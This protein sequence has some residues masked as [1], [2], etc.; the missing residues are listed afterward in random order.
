MSD[1]PFDESNPYRPPSA[2]LTDPPEESVAALFFATSQAKLAIMSIATLGIYDIW[3]FY[4]NWLAVRART[5]RKIRPGW[6]A[7][8]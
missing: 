2:A 3:W 5:G 4:K 8:G 6:R 7:S 1:R